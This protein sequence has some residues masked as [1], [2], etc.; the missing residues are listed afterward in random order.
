M[1]ENNLTLQQQLALL[2]SAIPDSVIDFIDD[3]SHPHALQNPTSREAFE[4]D[5]LKVTEG[6]LIADL[7]KL[8]DEGGSLESI[9][10]EQSGR[11]VPGGYMVR[12]GFKNFSRGIGLLV[13]L[14]ERTILK[15]IFAE[16]EYNA[17]SLLAQM[18]NPKT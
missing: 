6:Q 2:P 10:V 11:D 4:P 15:V 1:A 12:L 7:K 16:G 3:F 14:K 8:R 5:Y 9:S 13:K 18:K 17:D